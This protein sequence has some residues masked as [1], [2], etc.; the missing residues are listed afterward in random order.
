MTLSTAAAIRSWSQHLSAEITLRFDLTAHAGSTEFEEFSTLL[1]ENAQSVLLEKRHDDSERPPA[2]HLLKNL[3]YHA[4]PKQRELHPFLELLEIIQ[5]QGGRIPDDRRK[6][7]RDIATPAELKLYITPACPHCPKTVRDITVF[8]V[9][10]PL[11]NLSVIDGTMFPEM[12]LEDDIRSAPTV[13]LND[14]IRWS[15]DC[16][17]EEIIDTLQNQDLTDLGPAAIQ[18]MIENGSA[19]KLAPLMVKA[20]K[21]F[22]AIY[23]LLLDEKWSVR[24]GTMVVFETLAELDTDLAHS[25]AAFL[26][27]K[28]TDLDPSVMGDMIY[29]VG[30]C[31]NTDMLPRLEELQQIHS[32]DEIMEAIEEAVETIQEKG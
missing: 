6:N 7:I 2:I 12:A 11:L 32:S 24:L 8:P 16:P 30:I 28:L 17:A 9:V 26:L 4:V 22:P 3:I 21:I 29:L 31:G 23:D 10:N 18:S 5:N 19:D 25:G 20:G 13:V 1:A 27:E 14:A 15:G